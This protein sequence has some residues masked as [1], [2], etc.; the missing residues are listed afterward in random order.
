MGRPSKSVFRWISHKN[1]PRGRPRACPSRPPFAPDTASHPAKRRAGFGRAV[2]RRPAQYF[3]AR[4]RCP[5]DPKTRHRPNPRLHPRRLPARIE[6]SINPRQIPPG[7]RPERR[8]P[9]GA[10]QPGGL[11]HP[12][13]GARACRRS[14]KSGLAALQAGAIAGHGFLSMRPFGSPSGRSATARKSPGYTHR[15]CA[16]H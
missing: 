4:L 12:R 16:R 2:Q 9:D 8:P 10:P 1:P 3:V 14:G 13:I 6:T 5:D 11:R 7:A 15:R